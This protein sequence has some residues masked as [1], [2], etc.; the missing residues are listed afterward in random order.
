MA[1]RDDGFTLVEM[2]VSLA[3]LGMAAMMM[4]T[5]FS[6]GQ[7]IWMSQERRAAAGQSVEAAQ[8]LIRDRIERLHPATLFETGA[9]YADID[10][11]ADHVDFIA[12]PSDAERPAPM[13]RYRLSLGDR[14]QL[15]LSSP[16]PAA[17][18]PRSQP[19]L[20]GVREMQIS[21]FGPASDGGSPA[22]QEDWSR[23]ETPPE[24]VRVRLSFA[25]GDPRSWP[26]LIIRPAASVD[27]L[28]T[29][30][31]ETGRCRGR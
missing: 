3:L 9:A 19:V 29:I 13:R 17:G 4:A 24:L 6:S 20:G 7:R 27:T 26:E 8:S 30:M 21:Y 28:C 14:G 23:R 31:A 2:L 10:G 11:D 5:G 1:R 12:L 16:D 22:W 15:M 25:P 18:E